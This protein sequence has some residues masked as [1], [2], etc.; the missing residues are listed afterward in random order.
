MERTAACSCGRLSVTLSGDPLAHG[1]CSCL[2]CQ[3]ATGSAF[4]YTA[5]WPRS[6]IVRISGDSSVWRRSSDAGRWAETHFCP[7]C[8]SAVYRYAE[9]L[10]DT[11][12]V[13]IG[14][15]ADPSFATPQYA[16]WSRHKHAWLEI[17]PLCQV[18]DTQ[19]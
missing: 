17:P 8:G 14:S 6:A 13:S 10:P 15:L 5:Y 3:R 18:M 1:I 12:N 16:A 9:F 4:S 2:E 11:I 7:V 19:S